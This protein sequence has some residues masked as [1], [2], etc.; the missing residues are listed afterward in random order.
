MKQQKGF[1]LIELI[2]VIVILGILSAVALPRF[3][4]LSTEAD[5]AA[6]KGVVGG[7]ASA[8]AI[9]YAACSAVGNDAT[10]DQCVEVDNC[11][12][13][14]DLLQGGQAEGYTVAALSPAITANGTAEDCT[15]T[16]TSS[17]SDA[18]FSLIGAGL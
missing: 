12:D 9:N 10:T 6:L 18:D 11:E 7:Y 13:I 8:S 17:G 1:T 2:M 5:A 16:Q 14:S 15:V 4:D 3:V